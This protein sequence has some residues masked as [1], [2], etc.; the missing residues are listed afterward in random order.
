MSSNEISEI[1]MLVSNYVQ[2]KLIW[3]RMDTTEN[4][5][6]KVETKIPHTEAWGRYKDKHI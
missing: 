4:S 3:K 6:Q 5:V 2:S 1:K